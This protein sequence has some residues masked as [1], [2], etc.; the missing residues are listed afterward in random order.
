MSRFFLP[1]NAVTITF[2][3][4]S[5]KTS[6]ITPLRVGFVILGDLAAAINS[7]KLTAGGGPCVTEADAPRLATKA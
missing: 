4:H 7:A 1:N 6:F 2:I 3:L 5:M